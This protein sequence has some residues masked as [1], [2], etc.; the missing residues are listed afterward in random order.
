MDREFVSY[1]WD[2][3]IVFAPLPGELPGQG[4]VARLPRGG[5]VF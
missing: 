5:K 3:T 4:Q 1:I 2:M